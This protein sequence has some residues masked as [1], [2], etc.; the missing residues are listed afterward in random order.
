MIGLVL[1][2]L[3]YFPHWFLTLYTVALIFSLSLAYRAKREIGQYNKK[4]LHILPFLLIL[5]PT[6]HNRLGMEPAPPSK[7]H[8]ERWVIS[9]ML[10]IERVVTFPPEQVSNKLRKYLNVEKIL[11]RGQVNPAIGKA[12][13]SLYD[14]WDQ[15]PAY[16][17]RLLIPRLK[18]R[19]HRGFHNFVDSITVSI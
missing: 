18:L 7:N 14:Y 16:G 4:S 17:D 8:L 6:G 10:D 3:F 2:H 12:R 5:Y 19:P 1:G 13:L 15:L 11:S 9:E